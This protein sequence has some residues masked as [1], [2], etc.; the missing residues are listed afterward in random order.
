MICNSAP[1]II[2]HCL[3]MWLSIHEK[4]RFSLFGERL[5]V[6]AKGLK[7][8]FSWLCY[9][10]YLEERRLNRPDRCMIVK[11]GKRYVRQAIPRKCPMHISPPSPTP[12]SLYM[13]FYYRGFIPLLCALRCT[14]HRNRFDKLCR[15]A[16]WLKL[17]QVLGI[18]VF[19]Y[20]SSSTRLV[21][22]GN[23]FCHCVISERFEQTRHV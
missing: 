9:L 4:T 13:G 22:M 10:V 11:T 19:K 6:K 18:D 1:K 5:R 12:P 14:P 21:R 20:G 3:N 2:T 23:Y 17:I 16:Y 8:T 15:Q 7:S